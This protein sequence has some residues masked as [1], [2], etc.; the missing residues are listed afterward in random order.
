MRERER[1]QELG[2]Q[3]QVVCPEGWSRQEN[4]Q[5]I[6]NVGDGMNQYWP[7]SAPFGLQGVT[8]VGPPYQG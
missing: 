3:V 1:N 7:M 5:E 4:G 8:S 2:R 6:V